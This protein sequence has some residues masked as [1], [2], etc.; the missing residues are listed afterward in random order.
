[1]HSYKKIKNKILRFFLLMIL[2]V[3]VSYISIALYKMYTEIDISEYPNNRNSGTRISTNVLEDLP[4][5]VD[6]E[7]IVRTLEDITKCVVGVSKIKNLGSA[8][9]NKNSAEDLGLG[10][11]MIISSDGY[12]LTNW[13]VAGDRYANCYITLDNGNI[14]S[15]SIEWADSDLD[16][17]IVKINIKGLN[18][19]SLG[20]SD[21]IKLRGI[22]LCYW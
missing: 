22:S 20:D 17:A 18:Y 19:L 11:G 15:G 7:N 8:M 5:N 9:F 1:M 12:I 16:L 6:D 4:S 10:S 21:S 13:H 14:Y 3:L 2:M